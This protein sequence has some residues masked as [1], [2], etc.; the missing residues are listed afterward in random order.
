MRSEKQIAV[1]AMHIAGPKTGEGEHSM[2]LPPILLHINDIVNVQRA[3]ARL[4]ISE[5]QV[6][7]LFKEYRLGAQLGPKSPLEI[8][9][10]ALHMVVSGDHQALELLRAGDR[11]HPIVKRHFDHLGI[12]V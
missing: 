7:R 10:P 3:A 8:S 12:P 11:N 9:L 1:E 4:R 5:K 2:L 6:R